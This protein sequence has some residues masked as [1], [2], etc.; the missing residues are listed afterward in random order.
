MSLCWVQTGEKL[1]ACPSG[2]V[3]STSVSVAFPQGDDMDAA[4]FAQALFN[5]TSSALVQV[6]TL[7]L[8]AWPTA[9]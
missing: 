9:Q 6:S 1:T 8:P 7:P 4:D 5:I 3:C 2:A